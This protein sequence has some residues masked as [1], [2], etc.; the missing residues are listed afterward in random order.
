ME[1]TNGALLLREGAIDLMNGF[2]LHKLA[3]C[4]LAEEALKESARVTDGLA[5]NY[6]KVFNRCC[7]KKKAAHTV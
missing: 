6:L 3:K 4:F 5:F 2:V 7:V 1:T